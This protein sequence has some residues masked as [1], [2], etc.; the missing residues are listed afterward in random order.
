MHSSIQKPMPG[1]TDDPHRAGWRSGLAT[2]AV[3]LIAIL[4]VAPLS[5]RSAAAQSDVSSLMQTE[6][7]L[8]D[9]PAP[10]RVASQIGSRELSP[11][12]AR[13]MGGQIDGVDLDRV[14]VK[15]A[16]GSGV[17]HRD[18]RWMAVRD[19]APATAAEL[20]ELDRL[21][22][23]ALVG[24]I[25]RRIGLDEQQVTN[26]VRD[27]RA[28]TGRRLADMN[29]YYEL[30]LPE[31][32]TQG[33]ARDRLERVLREL[34]S[35]PI[36]EVA[37]AAPQPE[38]ARR[39]SP[40][41]AAGTPSP[42]EVNPTEARMRPTPDFSGDQGYFYEAPVG[43][44]AEAAWAFPGGLGEGVNVVDI[45]FGWRFTHE[46]LKAP[47][48]TS[49]DPG[50]DDHGT[51]VIGEICGQHNGFGVNGISPEVGIGG[52]SI[53]S[54]SLAAAIM[55]LTT[56]LG[57]GDIFVIEL[58][59]IGPFGDYIPMEFWQENYDA[60]Q[61]ASALGILCCEAAGNGTQDLDFE[62]YLS[63]FDR[64]V[65][66]SGAI[67]CGAGTPT[68]LS[69]EWFSNYGSRVDLQGWGSSV[70]T[71]GYGDLYNNGPDAIYTAGFNGTSSATPIVTG[72]A[73]SLQGQA[74]ELFGE[75]LTPALA[76]EILSRSGTSWEGDRQIGERP[77]I[78]AARDLLTAG[79]ADLTVSVRDA[80]TQLPLPGQVAEVLETG[81]L[82]KTGE[83]GTFAAQMSAG[84]FTFHLESF[85]YVAADVPVT[86]VA[87]VPQELVIDLDPAP[88]GS[89][90]GTVWLEGFGEAVPGALIRPLHPLLAETVSGPDGAFSIP[91]IPEGDGYEFVVGG[92][93]GLSNSMTTAQILADQIAQWHPILVP[94]E[95]FE[96]TD[97]GYTT[98]GVWAWGT[99]TGQGPGSAF[100]GTRCWA[101]NLAGQYPVYAYVNLDSPVFALGDA[102]QVLLSMHHWYWIQEFHDGGNVQVRFDGA[103]HVVEPFEGYDDDQI[104]VL[105][106]NPGFTGDSEGWRD[107]VFDVSAYASDEFQIRF[108]FGSGPSGIG[109]GWYVDDVA[110]DTGSGFQGIEW[111]PDVASGEPMRLLLAPTPN[112]VRGHT[113]VAFRLIERERIELT[114]HDTE[115]RQLGLLAS[116][117]FEPGVHR[118]NWSPGGRPAMPAGVYYVRLTTASGRDEVRPVVRIR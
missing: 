46:D 56:V 106:G 108:R 94:A 40:R 118:V 12:Q 26:L 27:A 23:Q 8:I 10:S 89:L 33:A 61:I 91:G 30:H 111:E 1:P 95:D 48:Y 60:I 50:T 51:A 74:L 7:S 25:Q 19:S 37:Y 2:M 71:T 4:L 115:G 43:V 14:V 44:E 29:L 85:F 103:W 59:A 55:D 75:E 24:R 36:V 105:S 69:A 17:R 39:V 21:V 78:L 9:E 58:H 52:A 16:E 73:A 32:G 93:A 104:G 114:L 116:G 110:I 54:Q 90:A 72:S 70:V 92:V 113:E 65:R 80:E 98:T 107:E 45:E 42:G 109:P 88:R 83:E 38:A 47:F 28:R 34:N 86:I 102:E 62:G 35:L 22:S 87:G 100:S 117:F 81:R 49:G 18:G 41:G 3:S 99:P 63:L 79:Y 6:V 67:M 5:G 68:G 13:L 76:Q 82:M 20:A 84:T 53:N 57:P 31:V 96:A 11:D 97:G 112:P 77:N 101:T 66:D 15:F 64:R